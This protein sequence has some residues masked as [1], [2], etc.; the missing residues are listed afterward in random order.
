MLISRC[1]TTQM[2]MRVWLLMSVSLHLLQKKASSIPA[3]TTTESLPCEILQNKSQAP[4]VCGER[5][6]SIITQWEKLGVWE[7]GASHSALYKRE[8]LGVIMETLALKTFT[9]RSSQQ[10][11]CYDG[12]ECVYESVW[13]PVKNDA[14][15]LTP[16]F[17]FVDESL[18]M[19][20]GN[21]NTL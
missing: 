8:K 21:F 16:A 19:E 5:K 17:Q 11:C 9:A 7:S 18:N 13:K 15:D 2:R 14:N 20:F 4:F 10:H 1:S 6:R 12:S 3:P